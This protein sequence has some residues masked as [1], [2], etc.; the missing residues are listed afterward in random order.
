MARPMVALVGRPNVGKSTLFN[1]L[2]GQRVAITEDIAGTTRDRNYGSADWAGRE[3]TVIDTGGLEI[4]P[5]SDI[6]QRIREQAE[7]AVAESDVIVFMVDGKT[8]AANEDAEI[9]ALL[10]Q[11]TKPVVVCVN[12]ADNEQRRL[13]AVEFYALGV[14][15][16]FPISALHGTGTG[17]LLDRVVEQLPPA[18]EEEESE[19]L[20]I[21]I[22]GRPNVGKSSLLNSILGEERAV[23]S[24]VPGTTRDVID[25]VVERDGERITLLDTAG[26][27]R[28]GRVEQG[29][30]KYSVI[31]TLRAIDRADIVFLVIDA[32]EG[33][34]AQDTHL[35]GY[36]LDAHRGMAIV[37][38]K[39]DLVTPKT[40]QSGA[41]Y[42][43]QVRTEFRFAAW[44]PIL[45]TSAKTGRGVPDM[46]DLAKKIES[47]RARRI[48]TAGLND[49]IQDAVS[50]H[51]PASNRGRRLRIYYATQASVNPPTFVFSVN[52]TELIHFTYERYLENRIREAFGFE[53]T[54]LRFF[55]RPHSTDR[56]E[57]SRSGKK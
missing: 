42:T 15:E 30:E 49:L 26:V 8:G 37:V 21:A 38:N 7:I 5:G 13:N 19:G 4:V 31:R 39:W 1:R 23:V 16:I 57:E 33:I 20:K 12:K 48:P 50:A 9:A 14:D 44:A 53:G 27:R 47:Q 55:F 51:Q 41:E 54:P 29:I 3:F 22:V 24:N 11:S 2:I 35:A 45:F 43:T 40:P 17:D 56:F 18:E 34:T 28:R 10:R 25:T 6:S 36:I 52:D 46:L 32:A